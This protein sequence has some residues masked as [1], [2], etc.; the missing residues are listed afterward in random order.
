MQNYKFN[1]N[2]KARKQL[3]EA[4]SEILE[5]KA[6]YKKT[7]T[8][9]YEIG[10]LVV[11]KEGTVTGEFPPKFLTS[12]AERGFVPESDVLEATTE[13]KTESSEEYPALEAQASEAPAEPELPI[14]TIS[15][16]VPLDGFSPE[17]IDNLCK[18]VLAK[19]SLIKLAIGAEALPIRVLSDRI[20]F[21]WFK[22]SDSENITEYTKFITALCD[23]AKRKKRVTARAHGEFE[24]P[25][26][27]MRTW[28]TALGMAGAGYAQIRRL[29]TAN[30]PGDGAYRYGKPENG[31]IPRKREHRHREVISIR[32]TPDTIEKLNAIATNIETETGQRTSRNMLIEQAAEAYVAAQTAE[33]APESETAGDT[34]EA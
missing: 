30:L 24:N 10:N 15:I 18:M 17:A 2:G 13:P 20:S 1:V 25:R 19:E 23:T 4:V 5:I 6:T 26:F 21:D 32:L 22:I 9:A 33:F 14:D 29:L 8:Y 7:P 27:S 11:D 31:V 16:D 12:L 3:V 28:L 34:P